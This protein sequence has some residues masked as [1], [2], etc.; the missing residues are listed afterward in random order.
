MSDRLTA[1][2]FVHGAG[3]GGWEWRIWARVFAAEGHPVAAPDL[4][5]VG[6]GL[7]ATTFAD[8]ARQVRDWIAAARADAGRVAVVGA[9]LGGLLAA[10]AADLADALVLVNPSPPSGLPGKGEETAIRPWR[11]RASLAGTR[12]TLPDA[13]PF[14]TLDAWRRWRDESGAVLAAARAGMAVPA[15]ACPVLVITSTDDVDVPPVG[16]ARLAA[17]W[18]ADLLRVRGSHVGPLL[19]RDAAAV[20]AQ[21]VT[22]LNGIGAGG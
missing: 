13:D 1:V 22:W 2:V 11:R 9:S 15:P 16:S 4:R 20:A 3:G 12:R 6:A 17:D 14:T 21:A 19:G 5:A 10:Q 7:A 18:G 8:Y